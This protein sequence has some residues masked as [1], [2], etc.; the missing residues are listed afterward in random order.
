MLI[1]FAISTRNYPAADIVAAAH[2]SKHFI[3]SER[4][5]ATLLPSPAL[6]FQRLAEAESAAQSARKCRVAIVVLPAMAAD[7]CF[8]SFDDLMRPGGMRR[9]T[10]GPLV[11]PSAEIGD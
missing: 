10:S 8:A 3:T 7:R 1:S 11:R 2:F 6:N 4:I 5:C 9:S